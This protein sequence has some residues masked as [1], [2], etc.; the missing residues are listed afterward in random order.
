ML[1][2]Y[3]SSARLAVEVDGGW[4]DHQLQHDARRDAWLESRGIRTLRI[5][6]E[7]VRVDLERVLDAIAE[8]AGAPSVIAPSAR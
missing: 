2:F 8:A 3:C 5:A 1:D 6:A 7:A 4:H